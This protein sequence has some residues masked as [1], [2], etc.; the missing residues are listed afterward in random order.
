MHQRKFITWKRLRRWEVSD[1]DVGLGGLRKIHKNALWKIISFKDQ[2]GP[3]AQSHLS[4]LYDL[5]FLPSLWPKRH[6]NLNCL[7]EERRSEGRR[8]TI[9]YFDSLP[10]VESSSWQKGE[11]LTSNH[12]WSF[13]YYIEISILDFGK[14]FSI[15]WLKASLRHFF[16]EDDQ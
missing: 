6:Q 11:V 8:L 13:D 2:L 15:W 9:H 3:R 16:L 7:R 12:I 5:C 10:P 1:Y 14:Q 4:W